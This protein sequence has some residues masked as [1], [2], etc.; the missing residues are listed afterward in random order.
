MSEQWPTPRTQGQS[1]EPAERDAL[2]LKAWELYS[3]SRLKKADIARQLSVTPRTV[4][5]LVQEFL[6]ESTLNIE[7]EFKR[8]LEM[9]D[10]DLRVAHN[11]Y[12]RTQARTDYLVV[13][14][15]LQRR[16]KMLGY[17]KHVEQSEVTVHEVTQADLEIM[18]IVNERKMRNANIKKSLKSNVD[19]PVAGD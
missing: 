17:D 16:A 8:D 3:V 19:S 11:K 2:K 14:M 9:L 6:R 4:N 18:D 12:S 5:E 10:R 15:I 13:D 7:E 1:M